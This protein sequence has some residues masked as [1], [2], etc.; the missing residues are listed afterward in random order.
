[1]SQENN[2]TRVVVSPSPLS[3]T[4]KKETWIKRTF[5]TVP[6][7]IF[8]FAAVARA[9]DYHM[10]LIDTGKRE[11]YCQI[12][13]SLENKTESQLKEIS[14]FFYSYMNGEEVGR[15]KGT[16]FMN[17][18]AG[19]TAEAVFETPNAPCEEVDRYE[20]VVGA[21]RFG[22]S[23]EDQELCATRIGFSNPLA[24]AGG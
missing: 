16:W 14:G 7:A 24:L 4:Q 1:M 2:V 20:F 15:S 13:V 10:T 22:Q 11:Y 3:Q 6:T 17:V 8:I 18:P 12:M 9:D 19:Q 21:C 23:F 5:L